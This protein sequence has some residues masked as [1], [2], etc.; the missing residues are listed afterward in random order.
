M[1]QVFDTEKRASNYAKEKNKNARKFR[2]IVLEYKKSDGGNGKKVIV[3]KT[4][5]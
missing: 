2:Y 1:V 4:T 5:K 3:K